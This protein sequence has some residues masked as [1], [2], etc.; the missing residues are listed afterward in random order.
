M[1]CPICGS[2]QVQFHP[3]MQRLKCSWCEMSIHFMPNNYPQ[4]VAETEDWYYVRLARIALRKKEVK[5]Q[6]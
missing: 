2:T 5:A 1:F 6:Y 3:S 4:D